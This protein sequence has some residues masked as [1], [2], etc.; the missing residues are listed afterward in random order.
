MK[1]ELPRSERNIALCAAEEGRLNAALEVVGLPLDHI[2]IQRFVMRVAWTNAHLFA[3][4]NRAGR[5][6]RVALIH[7]EGAVLVGVAP[8]GDCYWGNHFAPEKW[9]RFGFVVGYDLTGFEEAGFMLSSTEQIQL[10][11]EFG[12][13]LPLH[14]ANHWLDEVRLGQVALY[15][16]GFSRHRQQ[17]SVCALTATQV[18]TSVGRFHRRS[19]L[20]YLRGDRIDGNGRLVVCETAHNGECAS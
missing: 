20:S 8:H 7:P 2:E 17:T 18:V 14:S 9:M 3:L 4:N 15:E 11:H 1:C 12:R 13:I 10:K 6:P 16:S 5:A 19:G